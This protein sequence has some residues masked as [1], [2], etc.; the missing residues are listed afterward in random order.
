MTNN[1]YQANNLYWNTFYRFTLIFRQFKLTYAMSYYV[2]PVVLLLLQIIKSWMKNDWIVI[3]TNI[4][5]SWSFVTQIFH[6]YI[7][8]MML[9]IASMSLTPKIQRNVPHTLIYTLTLKTDFYDTIN[10]FNISIVSL[11][12]IYV[13]VTQIFRNGY[14]SHGG[15]RKTFEEITST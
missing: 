1:K 2:I 12:F 15:D 3:T 4:I 14:P 9:S 5:Y 8:C 7:C 13:C 6:Q 11:L 10:D